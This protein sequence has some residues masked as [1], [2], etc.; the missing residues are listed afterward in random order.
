MKAIPT[1]YKGIQFRSRLEA[2]WAAFFDNVGWKWE[3]EPCDFNGYIPDFVLHFATPLYVEVK[4]AMSEDELKPAI[5]KAMRSGCP[6]ILALLASP[7]DTELWNDSKRIGI[8]QDEHSCQYDTAVLMIC[9]ECQN[10]TIISHYGGW[11]CRV[12]GAWDGDHYL[13]HD[14]GRSTLAWADAKNKAQ[15]RGKKNGRRLD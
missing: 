2:T 4:P 8:I 3:Y 15:W 13:M 7:V 12:C 1:I 10:L 9:T 11:H 14:D 5:D 6:N